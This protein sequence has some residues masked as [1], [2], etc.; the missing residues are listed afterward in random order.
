MKAY[1]V[2]TGIIFGLI[3]TAHV[4]RAIAEGPQL[5]RDPFFLLL[6]ALAASLCV[7]SFWL[8]RRVAK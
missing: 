5:A 4:W 2:T 7:W 6:T 3:T 1:L 8:F